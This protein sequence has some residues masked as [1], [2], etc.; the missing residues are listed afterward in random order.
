MLDILADYLEWRKFKFC[1]LDGRMNLEDRALQ[2]EDFRE[3]PDIRVFLI[4]TRAG[5]L[6][7]NLTAADTVIIY[8]SDWVNMKSPKLVILLIL[9]FA[10]N[11][12]VLPKNPQADLQAQDRCH[13]IGQSRPVIV[14]RLVTADTI[15]QRII[16]RAGAKRKLEKMVIQK[17]WMLFSTPF[18]NGAVCYHKLIFYT[19]ILKESL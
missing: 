9:F 12:C 7:L 15:D 2:M 6:G 4:S 8:D 3:D 10:F 17:G 13:R 18:L 1:R 14:Y 11:F 19:S 16:D 5:G